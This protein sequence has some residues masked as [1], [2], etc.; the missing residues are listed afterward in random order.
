[1]G[2]QRQNFG[3]LIIQQINEGFASIKE[4]A[5]IKQ[6]FFTK[7]LKEY[8][9][10]KAESSI[11]QNFF[12][13]LPRLT[14]EFIAILSI[15]VVSV[16][17]ISLEYNLNQ[18]L[19][20]VV[21]FGIICF[22]LL[23]ASNRILNYLQVSI[24]HRSVIKVLYDQLYN[25]REIYLNKTDSKFD[26]VKEL[27]FKDKISLE[28][29]SFKY[30]KGNINILKNTNIEINKNDFFGIMGLSGSGKS[31][32]ITLLMGIF[33]PD[34]GTI[35]CDGIDIYKNIDEWKNKIGYVPQDVFKK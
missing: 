13:S 14:F 8:S 23:P 25:S 33:K 32:L 3:A 1:M 4:I 18:I 29:I 20:F 11:Y 17:M 24:Y 2:E 16:L 9:H 22:R 5:L 35:K 10:K 31:T 15:L 30:P 34:S 28:N 21:V 19:Q 6:S 7:I 12:V 26:V 27:M